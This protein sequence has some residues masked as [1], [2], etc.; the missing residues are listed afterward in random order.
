MKRCCLPKRFEDFLLNGDSGTS[1]PPILFRSETLDIRL[2]SHVSLATGGQFADAL[3]ILA[4]A[5]AITLQPPD[6]AALE[7]RRD[8]FRSLR[9]RVFDIGERGVEAV[10]DPIG[11][12]AVD[13][14]IDAV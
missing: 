11:R 9:E 1:P 5:L 4:S 12:G 7:Q 10:E 6:V 13:Q 2:G 8:R 3:P 14:R